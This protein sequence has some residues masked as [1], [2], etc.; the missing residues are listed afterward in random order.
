M[1]KFV[2]EIEWKSRRYWPVK[3]RVKM[4]RTFTDQTEALG[5]MT[6]ALEMNAYIF[7]PIVTARV[8]EMVDHE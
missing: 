3:K 1:S 8:T 7:R 5:W 2:V 6:S 4:T